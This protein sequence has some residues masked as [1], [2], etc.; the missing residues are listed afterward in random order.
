MT[1]PNDEYF[2]TELLARRRQLAQL[3][4]AAFHP[5]LAVLLADVDAALDRLGQGTYHV[6]TVCH[7]AIQPDHLAADPLAR[8]CWE[9]STPAEAARLDRDLAL[10]RRIQVGLLPPPGRSIRGWQFSYRYEAAAEVGGD[11]CDVIPLP[12]DNST[13]VLVGDVSGKGIAASILMA[14]L[15]ATF[16]S[17]SRLGLPAGD[18]LSRANDLFYESTP[19]DAFATLAAAVLRPGGAADVYSAGHWPPLLLHAGRRAAPVAVKTGLP[20]GAFAGSRYEPVRLTLDRSTTLLFFT[21]GIVEAEDR[22]G[23]DY[24]ASRL[25]RV[26]ADARDDRLDALVARCVGDLRRFQDAGRGSDDVLLL[27]IR[28]GGAGEASA[29]NAA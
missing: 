18:L 1:T 8:C 26:L 12:S 25:A 20:L 19:P 29:T 10:A 21:D 2:R 24:G 17:L 28:A 4:P 3:P 23:R 11:F 16:R 13:L 22:T 6:C 14:S 27:A 5:E 7:E 9:H 15:L